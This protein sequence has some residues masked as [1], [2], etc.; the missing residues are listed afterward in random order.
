MHYVVATQEREV[1]Q[2]FVEAVQQQQIGD[3]IVMTLA[4]EWVQEGKIEGKIET[5]EKLLAMQMD[6]SFIKEVT[7]VDQTGYQELKR[8]LA[9]LREQN[10]STIRQLTSN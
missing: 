2:Q 7:D 6:W 9:Q 8:Q 3:R 1:V 4:E 5:I 10:E